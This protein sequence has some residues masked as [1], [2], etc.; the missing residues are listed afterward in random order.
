M[1]TGP[2]LT[3]AFITMVWRVERLT[4]MVE[5]LTSW[6]LINVVSPD[7][8][9]QRLRSRNWVGSRV[10]QSHRMKILPAKY[11]IMRFRTFND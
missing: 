10:S 3:E 11:Y 5:G 2:S 4:N 8:K 6:H 9:G 1:V 7:S